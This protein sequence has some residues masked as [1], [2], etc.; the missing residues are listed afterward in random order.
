M[1]YNYN[2]P[3]IFTMFLLIVFTSIFNHFPLIYGF[4]LVVEIRVILIDI[5]FHIFLVIHTVNSSK[6]YW[7][8]PEVKVVFYVLG[9][10]VKK[11]YFVF[12]F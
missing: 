1:L 10:Y 8:S 9:Q 4:I 7:P 3:V 5:I 12:I 2:I 11:F 6:V